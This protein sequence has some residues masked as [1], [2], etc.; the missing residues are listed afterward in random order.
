MSL[1]LGSSAIS[2]AFGSV[3]FFMADDT[4]TVRVDVR[5]DVLAKIG[6]PPPKTKAGLVRLLGQHRRR[7]AQIAAFKYDEGNYRPEVRVLVVDITE[8]D[9]T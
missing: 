2:V 9:L 1:S 8:A 3:S 5:Q 4:K 7:F 6:G